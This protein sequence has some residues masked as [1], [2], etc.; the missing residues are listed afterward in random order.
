MNRIK[1]KTILAIV[2]ICMIIPMYA[3]A[4]PP[5]PKSI[6]GIIY[7][8]DGVTEVPEG[9]SFSV[10]DTTS[11]NNTPG[12]TGSGPHTGYYSVVLMENAGDMIEIMGWNATHHGL[13]TVTLLADEMRNIDVIINIPNADDDITP[14]ASV[15]NLDEVDKGTT[16][17]QWEWTNP[18]DSDFSH[19]EVYIDGVFKEN[20]N[21]PG[22]SYNADGLSPDTTYEIGT[23]TVDESGNINTESVTDTATTLPSD[24]PVPV[25]TPT[26]IVLLISLLALVGFVVLRR[27]E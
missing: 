4:A 22:D 6:S 9:T 26:G 27:K 10:N 18:S 7:M 12:T 3:Q 20:V 19:T 11:G 17:I 14:P 2:I 25:I 15:S 8:S 1:I 5:M 24:V 21:T 13:T 16:W 23:R